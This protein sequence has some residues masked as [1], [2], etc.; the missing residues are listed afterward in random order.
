MQDASL[1]SISARLTVLE[2]RVRWYQRLTLAL[3]LALV[4]GIS[5]AARAVPAVTDVLQVRRL[6]VMDEA[7][8]V[9]FTAYATAV[10]GRIEVL[11]H[12]GR[13]VFSAGA[14]QGGKEPV[15]LWEQTLQTIDRQGRELD[16]QRRMLEDLG[17]QLR[18]LP[19]S[20]Q[21]S[22]SVES[23]SQDLARLRQDVEQQRLALNNVDRQLQ[24]L[25]YQL[26]S[27]ERR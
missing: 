7:G 14:V 18:A 24:S 2:R 21:A 1:A 20:R 13:Q 3:G 12:A 16:Q 23:Q 4:C 6:E 5:L 19:Q 11:N 10:G 22:G 26:R 25:V 15:G 27:L 8:K 9:G 17:R